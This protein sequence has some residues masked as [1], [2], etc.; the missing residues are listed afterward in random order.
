VGV[1]SPALRTRTLLGTLCSTVANGVLLG[2]MVQTILDESEL[3]DVGVGD[4]ARMD[5]RS[6]TESKED[7]E[8]KESDESDDCDAWEGDDSMEPMVCS[9]AY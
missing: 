3:E 9:E 4:N 8:E 1:I 5:I 6:G 2:D 7:R